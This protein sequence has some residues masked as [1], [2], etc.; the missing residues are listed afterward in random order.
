MD[1]LEK[2]AVQNLWFRM[3]EQ[4]KSCDA[5]IVDS[6]SPLMPQVPS[7][8]GYCAFDDNI[9]HLSRG[10]CDGWGR[11]F[12]KGLEY[13]AR[14][15]YEYAVHIECDSLCTLDIAKEVEHME[16]NGS[17]VETIRVSSMP[18][19]PETG[20]MLFD[21]EWLRQT[22]FVEKYDWQRRSKY[23][24]P[25]RIIQE[26]CGFDLQLMPWRGMRDDFNELTVDNVADRNLDWLTHASLPVMER[27]AGAAAAV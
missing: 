22:N 15:G 4:N 26:L 19:W 11:A 3:A 17:S 16:I 20:L 13:A 5:M 21:V 18:S 25:E 27:F 10:G 24:E 6:C 23:P 14:R 9:G 7:S 8:V 12:C 2:R 1:T